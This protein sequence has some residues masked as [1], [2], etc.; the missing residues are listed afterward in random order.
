M[1]GHEDWLKKVWNRRKNQIENQQFDKQNSKANDPYIAHRD[2]ANK[3]R[4]EYGY[5]D[6]PV[7]QPFSAYEE[8]KKGEGETTKGGNQ[9]D[10]DEEV[11]ILLSTEPWVDRSD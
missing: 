10:F 8:T 4:K 11:M 1:K 6:V 3:L 9:V 7:A 5:T 2:K